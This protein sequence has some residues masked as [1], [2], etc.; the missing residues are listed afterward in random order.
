M[1]NKQPLFKVEPIPQI[2][3]YDA[4]HGLIRIDDDYY[5]KAISSLKEQWDRLEHL[6]SLGLIAK[7]FLSATHTKKEHHIGTY[8]LATEVKGLKQAEQKRLCLNCLIRGIGHLPYT[9][10]A[11]EGVLLACRIS[12]E[13]AD[14]LTSMLQAV[15]KMCK[16]RNSSCKTNCLKRMVDNYDCKE[17][18][19]WLSAY[20]IQQIG[21]SEAIGGDVAT[22]V[23]DLVCKYNHINQMADML[24]R[25]D[26][27]QRDLRYSAIG[28]IKLPSYTILKNFSKPFREEP[29]RI[30]F[31]SPEL[32]LI[33]NVRSYLDDCLYTDSRVTALE[34]LFRKQIADLILR[35]EI[36][37]I[38]LM[39]W[40]DTEL[41]SRISELSKQKQ[42]I[43][44]LDG[45]REM[46]W[47]LV[48]QATI[49][50]E[51]RWQQ[52]IEAEP[53]KTESTITGQP[54]NKLAEY[55][56]EDRFFVGVVR[57]P[58]ETSRVSLLTQVENKSVH[59][60]VYS[61][62]R[63]LEFL[64]E[65]QGDFEVVD[66]FTVQLLK[67]LLGCKEIVFDTQYVQSAFRNWTRK[68]R[69]T[70]I[71][72][73]TKE[74]ISS[75]AK[76]SDTAIFLMRRQ[77][78]TMP[79]V[80]YQYL[81]GD[82]SLTLHLRAFSHFM[83]KDVKRS[84]EEAETQFKLDKD[85]ALEVIAYL[86]TVWKHRQDI[87]IWARPLPTFIFDDGEP[88]SCDVVCL[89]L[90]E[91]KISLELIECTTQKSTKKATEDYIKVESKIIPALRNKYDDLE[92]VPLQYSM[93][94]VA[95]VF[96]NAEELFK[97]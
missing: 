40:N 38:D 91:Q 26:Y 9:Y 75:G 46:N 1:S 25:I 10:S 33:A 68:R 58:D 95:E 51:D 8:Y 62:H 23:N 42:N 80:F 50:A 11:E 22:I 72:K 15:L 49:L 54:I 60:I 14:E 2:E 63:L 70:E 65:A 82:A 73:L 4:I 79:A 28:E 56:R 43:I 30:S 44:P 37:I 85:R 48:L 64:V 20:K 77:Y 69:K 74:I 24:G 34:A 19:K 5:L 17:L 39:S 81:I 31:D 92:V 66:D 53:L 86:H 35:K 32:E 27:I 96:Q 94:P 52:P 12:K 78:K 55:P 36:A 76:E 13:I 88:I 89:S 7:V 93:A 21:L 6:H 57:K 87:R 29:S 16:S 45:L 47:P 71:E 59:S 97:V 84:L 90:T 41:E 3:H 61:T 18:Y 67:L 83:L